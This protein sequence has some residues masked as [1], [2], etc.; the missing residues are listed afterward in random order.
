MPPRRGLNFVWVVV[1]QRCRT[2]GAGVVGFGLWP[3]CRAT[4]ST[5]Q[6]FGTTVRPESFTIRMTFVFFI[7]L[8]F[9]IRL[10]QRKYLQ[11]SHAVI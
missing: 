8:N 10:S 6:H 11:I 2:Y 9:G 3:T 5:L 7:W 1:L 4:G